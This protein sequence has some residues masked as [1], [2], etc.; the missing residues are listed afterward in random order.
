MLSIQFHSYIY[1]FKNAEISEMQP[2][3]GITHTRPTARTALQLNK[4]IRVLHVLTRSWEG[5]AV[6]DQNR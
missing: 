2:Y 4:Q 6:W 5:R 1:H 3:G